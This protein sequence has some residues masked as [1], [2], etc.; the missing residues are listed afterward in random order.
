MPRKEYES[1]SA[2]LN[3]RKYSV[4]ISETYL[5]SF[6]A[7]CTSANVNSVRDDCPATRAA[8]FKTDSIFAHEN[9]L[10]KFASVCGVHSAA[11]GFPA[12]YIS[13]SFSRDGSSGYGT[14]NRASNRPGRINAS[15]SAGM[16]A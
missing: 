8:R 2:F 12:L 9:P 6:I 16:E 5:F 7:V 13:T 14:E 15:S 1:K 4:E 3:W 11:C 10:N